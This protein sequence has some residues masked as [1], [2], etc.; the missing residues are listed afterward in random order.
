MIISTKNK[1]LIAFF[2]LFVISI[3][4]TYKLPVYISY[5]WF[6][7]LLIL[8]LMAKQEH[9]HLWLMFF[10]LLFSSPGYLFY[11]M[12]I[13][14]LPTIAFPGED[15]ELYYPEIFIILA[16]IKAIVYP[17]KQEFFYKQPLLIIIC[18]STLLLVQ[19]FFQGTSSLTVLKSLRY[20]IPLLILYF[21]PSLIP[22]SLVPRTISLMFASVFILLATQL[23][24]LLAGLPIAV[25]LGETHIMFSGQEVNVD[26]SV[27]NVS[28]DAVRTVYGPFILLLSLIISMIFLVRK[29][30]FFK[31]Y[32][33]VL[34]SIL[35]S[36]S[37]FMS[38]T[39]GWIIAVAFLFI[40]LFFIGTKK[41][42]KIALVFLVLISIILTIPKINLQIIQVVERTLTIKD[43]AKGDLTAGGSL[44]RLTERGP[45]VMKKFYEQPVLGYGFSEEYYKFLDGHVGN[46]SLLLNG[47]I[48]GFTIYLIFILSFLR[49]YIIAYV[50]KNNNTAFIFIFGLLSLIIIHSS[51]TMVFAYALNVDI[52]IA[53]GLFMFFSAY[54]IDHNYK[55]YLMK[56]NS[57]V[58]AHA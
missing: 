48:I 53:L 27:F 15:R 7:A 31:N 54:F 39:R 24:D 35:S 10:W 47:G 13:Y 46:Q 11:K 33:V 42:T 5:L 4:F 8:F 37:I 19:G 28:T 16:I 18:F 14:H 44:S 40:G 58:P 21:I 49:Y 30:C 22:Y 23:I 25:I 32:Y 26:S 6:W 41:F 34:I 50:N 38:A 55:M 56:S 36:F 57:Q 29:N 9:N 3:F 12:G 17:V 20:F 52:A 43:L 45:K 2:G 1:D 51:S